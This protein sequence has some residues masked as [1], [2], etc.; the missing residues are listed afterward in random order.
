MKFVEP[1]QAQKAGRA[2]VAGY[3]ASKNKKNVLGKRKHKAAIDDEYCSSAWIDRVSFGGLSYPKKELVQD[4]GKMDEMF[5]KYNHSSKDGL[6][7]TPKVTKEFTKLLITEFPQ[8]EKRMLQRFSL[9]R[10]IFRMR[11]LQQQL[12]AKNP[13]TLRS[14]IKCISYKY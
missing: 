13:E 14:V 5:I 2:Y 11:W 10:H 8:Y 3:L 1:N 12:A 9:S 7:R 4:V 6:L